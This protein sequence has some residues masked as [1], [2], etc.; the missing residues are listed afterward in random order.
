MSAIVKKYPA[1]CLFFLAMI[2]A[3][4]LSLTVATGWLP[5]AAA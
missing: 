4:A 3:T 2:F 5:P 1:I